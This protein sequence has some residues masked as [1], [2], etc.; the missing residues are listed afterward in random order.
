MDDPHWV[1]LLRKVSILQLQSLADNPQ[2]VPLRSV[3]FSNL[4]SVVRSQ[5]AASHLKVVST[6]ISNPIY[7][8][9][10]LHYGLYAL[11]GRAISHIVRILYD[12]DSHGML[13]NS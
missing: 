4:T 3:A 2:H 10:L 8:Q 13:I 11:L 7:L 5:Y 9:Y 1:I 12:F 6:L